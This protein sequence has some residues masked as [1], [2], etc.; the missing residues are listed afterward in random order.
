MSSG[1]VLGKFMP[2]HN[3]HRYLIDFA[4][5]YC[6]ELTIVVG[7]LACEPIPGTLR[8]E[9]MRELY[10][11]Q[12]VV[13]VTDENPQYPHEH[14]DFWAIWRQTL[15]RALG[16]KPDYLFASEEYGQRLAE[17]LGASYV[18]TNGLRGLVAVSGSQIRQDPETHW[19]HLP[20]CVRPYF[21]R[22]ICVFGPESSGKST[23]AERLASHYQTVWVPE[24]AR[25]YLERQG[26]FET[27]DIE[28]IARGQLASEQALA[29]RARW[30]MFSDTDLLTTSIWADWLLQARHPWLDRQIEAQHYD[31]YL[32]CDADLPWKKDELRYLPHH[33][34]QF[35]E[36][37][38]TELETRKRPYALI[39]GRGE[40]RFQLAL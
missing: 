23:L 37:C 19:Q 27:A 2:V 14:P 16:H 9:W 36:R 32:L 39:S 10:P 26:R 29:R 31:L 24:Y 13:H 15:Q 1:V 3:G 35:L 12:R 28:P 21:V 30:L 11:A 38:R 20:S 22:R 5:H 4:R 40:E 34:R 17:E 25:L 8:V 6:D 18:P 33:G 7:S